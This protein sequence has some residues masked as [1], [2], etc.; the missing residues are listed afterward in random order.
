MEDNVRKRMY[1]RMCDW[2]SLL[3]CRKLTEHCKPTIM[4]KI[5]KLK[6]FV[7]EPCFPKFLIDW[8]PG[9]NWQVETH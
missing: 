5:K 4:E 8:G 2:V 6:I 9:R 7:S 1:I 3:Y